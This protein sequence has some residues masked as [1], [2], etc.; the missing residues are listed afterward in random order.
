MKRFLT[1]LLAIGSCYLASP[2][3]P[4][5][6]EPKME[7]RIERYYTPPEGV[8]AASGGPG[9][10]AVDYLRNQRVRAP[11]SGGPCGVRSDQPPMQPATKPTAGSTDA[12]PNEPN[13]P[14]DANEPSQTPYI[15][16]GGVGVGALALIVLLFIRRP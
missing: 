11:G 8:S 5:S 13:E 9:V 15:V 3:A 10:A 2:T 14:N 7:S 4:A 12:M 1:P 16:I 6:I